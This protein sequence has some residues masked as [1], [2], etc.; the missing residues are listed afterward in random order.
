VDADR[1]QTQTALEIANP[2]KCTH[3]LNGQFKGLA[4]TLAILAQNCLGHDRVSSLVRVKKIVSGL[5]AEKM[6]K[7]LHNSD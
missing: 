1:I 2:G 4:D 3:T 7:T 6:L 5:G